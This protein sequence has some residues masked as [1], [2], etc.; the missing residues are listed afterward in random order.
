MC[1]FYSAA[2]TFAEAAQRIPSFRKVS[3]LLVKPFSADADSQNTTS[4]SIVIDALTVLDLSKLH[5]MKQECLPGAEEPK[6][7]IN[8]KFNYIRKKCLHVHAEIQLINDFESRRAESTNERVVH[9]YIGGSNLCI[10]LCDCFLRHYDF[11]QYRGCHWKLYPQWIV[12]ESFISG[13]AAQMFQDCLH[14][15]HLDILAQIKSILT[16]KIMPSKERLLLE[17]TIDLSSV[18]TVS[19]RDSLEMSLRP[20]KSNYLGKGYIY[21]ITSA[22]HLHI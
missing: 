2:S 15:V 10:H 20:R 18:A 11:F 12:A 6:S 21:F 5:N 22:I 17:S 14:R 7:P 16:G 13:H 8:L 19:S 1:R 4:R 9:P 3:F